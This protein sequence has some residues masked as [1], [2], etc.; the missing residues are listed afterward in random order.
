MINS[1]AMISNFYVKE[2]NTHI[3]NFTY[4]NDLWQED[5][6]SLKKKI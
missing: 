1:K 3:Y 2:T 4:C 6:Y 5:L